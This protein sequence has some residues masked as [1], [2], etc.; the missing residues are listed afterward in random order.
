[1]SVT[2]TYWRVEYEYGKGFA[3]KSVRARSR[4]ATKN[5]YHNTKEKAVESFSMGDTLNSG[6]SSLRE[7]ASVMEIPGRS[8]MNKAALLEAV[9]ARLV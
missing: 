6:L 3:L 5:G 9:S 4:A 7:A 8:K 2:K 1:M